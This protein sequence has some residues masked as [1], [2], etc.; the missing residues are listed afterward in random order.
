MTDT[1][2]T[3]KD[4]T[5]AEEKT[6]QALEYIAVGKTLVDIAKKILDGLD[7]KLP[8]KDVAELLNGS[9][10]WLKEALAPLSAAMDFGDLHWYKKQAK[11]IRTS[12]TEGISTDIAIQLV[13]I[14]A[15]ML[16]GRL[17]QLT[18]AGDRADRANKKR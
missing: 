15:N 1:A 12:S 9:G 5:G 2:D 18:S 6:D 14:R 17:T 4:P 8:A 7:E 13:A 10:E 16:S 3:E 11:F